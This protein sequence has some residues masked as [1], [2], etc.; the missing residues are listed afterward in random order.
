MPAELTGRS[1]ESADES[2]PVL[3]QWKLRD[4]ERGYRNLCHLAGT[5]GPEPLQALAHALARILP[6]CPDPDMALNNLERFLA[7]AG[8]RDRLPVLLEPRARALETLLQ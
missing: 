8:G 6:R 4:L 7:S 3:R 5:I 2:R 1:L